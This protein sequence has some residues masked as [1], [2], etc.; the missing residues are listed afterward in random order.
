VVLINLFAI[1]CLAFKTLN[2]KLTYDLDLIICA[3]SD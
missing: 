1:D 3:L 2:H